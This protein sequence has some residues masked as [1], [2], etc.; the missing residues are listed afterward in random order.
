MEVTENVKGAV[1][2]SLKIVDCIRGDFVSQNPPFNNPVHWRTDCNLIAGGER[3]GKLLSGS[4][5]R[6][7]GA[8]LSGSVVR[9][10]S[11]A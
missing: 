10:E 8:K 11:I 9:R 4:V 6:R 3:V 1:I 7:R 2:I 5:V